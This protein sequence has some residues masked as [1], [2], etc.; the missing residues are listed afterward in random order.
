[1]R[2]PAFIKKLREGFSLTKKDVEGTNSF[3]ENLL[4]NLFVDWASEDAWGGSAR[5][6]MNEAEGSGLYR[7]VLGL[8]IDTVHQCAGVWTR[9]DAFSMRREPLLVSKLWTY[10]LIDETAALHECNC[11]R[12]YVLM[13]AQCLTQ[14]YEV[15]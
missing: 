14:Q 6:G 13:C 1:M 10:L 8:R 9:A 11:A 3:S 7:G 4:E 2:S 12:H 15:T 5:G